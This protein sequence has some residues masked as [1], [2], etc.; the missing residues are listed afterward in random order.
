MCCLWSPWAKEGSEVRACFPGPARSQDPALKSAWHKQPGRD[1]AAPGLTTTGS[2]RLR[3]A[4]FSPRHTHGS[5]LRVRSQRPGPQV[6]RGN[7]HI[8]VVPL[9]TNTATHLDFTVIQLNPS[10]T[11]RGMSCHGDFAPSKIL[12]SETLVDFGEDENAQLITRRHCFLRRCYEVSCS[13][14]SLCL[15]DRELSGP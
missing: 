1:A 11:D 14:Y 8:F 15:E 13:C 10:G 12:A 4:A 7:T 6:T 2:R 9:Q 5:R 3:S